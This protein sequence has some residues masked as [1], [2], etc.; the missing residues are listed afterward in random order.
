MKCVFNSLE[1]ITDKNRDMRYDM[2]VLFMCV[3]CS[4]SVCWFVFALVVL[5]VGVVQSG[6]LS[7]SSRTFADATSSAPVP[8]AVEG[9][10]VSCTLHQPRPVHPNLRLLGHRCHGW[11]WIKH[12]FKR[13]KIIVLVTLP[14][15]VVAAWKKCKKCKNQML[16]WRCVNI[17]RLNNI[18]NFIY[19]TV[20]RIEK[21]WC[22]IIWKKMLFFSKQ[23]LIG[24][25]LRSG[26]SPS[27][28][29]YMW[30]NGRGVCLT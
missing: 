8:A 27:R 22:Y 20:M 11:V 24:W 21:G 4:C 25:S 15:I 16:P 17:Y 23:L 19:I 13:N 29:T 26:W 5:G 7:H 30:A 2:F 6:V 1:C 3:Y 28:L 18:S 14:M 12:T 9:G 10:H